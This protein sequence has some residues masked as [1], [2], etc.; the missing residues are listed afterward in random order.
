M[1]DDGADRPR[2]T[3]TRAD[4]RAARRRP[5]RWDSSRRPHALV[6]ARARAAPRSTPTS[7]A[8][9]SATRAL[10][11]PARPRDFR[12][13]VG[14]RRPPGRS[15]RGT[16]P[17]S[18][19]LTGVNDR[20]ACRL[21]P[22]L[23]R[24]HPRRRA[25]RP[26][27]WRA[28]SATRP[29]PS[30]PPAGLCAALHADLVAL[31]PRPGRCRRRRDPATITLTA[32]DAARLRPGGW[33]RW[34]AAFGSPRDA[35]SRP[36]A[37]GLTTLG[38]AGLLVATVPSVLQGR[39]E[40]RRA[41]RPRPRKHRR[42]A[43]AAGRE[44][45][46]QHA[47]PAGPAAA[48]ACGRTHPRTGRGRSTG[49]PASR[50]PGSR[51]GSNDGRAP[52]GSRLGRS[53]SGRHHVRRRRRRA[54]ERPRLPTDDPAT[55]GTERLLVD[56]GTGR[57]PD[58]DPPVGR[59][60]HRRARRCSPSAGRRGASATTEPAGLAS[61]RGP[62]LHLIRA[63]RTPDAARRL[64]ARLPRLLRPAAPDDVQGRARQR[65][66]RLRE[67]RPARHRRTSSP[68]TSRS[69]STC[70]G[71]T[72]RHEQ[73]ADYKATRVTDAGRPARPVPEGPRGGQGAAHPGLRAAGLRGRRRH[74]H[75]H[76]PARRQRRARDDDRDRRSR[77]APAGHAAGPAD[78]DP[79]GRREHGH[80]RRRQDRRAVR[81]APGPDD[82]LQGA[83]GRPDRQH[84]GRARGR[85]ED[86]READPRVRRPRLAATRAS[87][88]SRPSQAARQAAR[89][90]STRSGWAASC[91]RSCATCR[92][93]ST[94][95]RRAS[96]TTT[97]T[98]SSGCSA[99]TSSARSSSG[100]RRWPARRRSSAPSA[101]ASVADERLRAGGAR[102]RPAGWLGT[103]AR[104][105]RGRRRGRAPAP[106][107][108]RRRV[109]PAAGRREL[110]RRATSRRRA[111]VRAGQ[112]PADGPRRG[113]PGSRPD[114]GPRRGPHR[115]P[116]AVAGGPVGGR[117]GARARRSAAAARRRRWRSRSPG[118]D[119]RVVAVDGPEAAAA[120]RHLLERLR[121]PARRARGQADPRRGASPRTTARAPLPVAFDTQ[122]AAYILNAALRSQ[123]IADVV[124]ENARPDPAAAGRAAGHGPGR[125]RGAVGARR[126]RAA[127]A[128]PRRGQPRAPV[129]RGRA[130]ADPGPR[131]DGSGRR[132]PRPRG[133]GR[134]RSRV[135]GRDRA[136]R[137]G[138][139]RTTSAT[140]STSAARSSSS[141]S[142]SSSSTCP[143][144][145]AR[146]P[147][148]RP[149][150]RCSRTCGRR[151]R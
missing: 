71:P 123:T 100:C 57:S 118:A 3:T 29:K 55:P 115:R 121:H 91:R 90:P 105:N 63:H 46:D 117:R 20:Y 77:H 140:S 122:V 60:A 97:A 24:H 135:R 50:G 124:A 51:A 108:L 131:P 147:A 138:D 137:G 85:R 36:L 134:P 21:R 106:P 18:P 43:P 80:V 47:M 83:Q 31:R 148:T 89:A 5:R 103:G 73:Y 56:E 35:F 65:R 2:R 40:P 119:G 67:H 149:T 109:G 4:R 99:S 10:P 25:R 93:S 16:G 37:V 45:R 23:A 41:R 17:S 104:R 151:I 6:A 32:A 92:S 133:A 58:A 61:S 143:R 53:G 127:R 96:A 84:P 70:P 107:R 116:R 132:R 33:R 27:A 26:L 114:R 14:R 94:W 88:R 75:D 112:G 34:V 76:P 62:P 49:A 95:R 146:R 48:P 52:A 22:R 82:R 145:S 128:A 113:D 79:L 44:P 11:V 111:R 69:P 81:P 54:G 9:S 129:P 150:R 39:V 64:R 110:G 42:R 102:R 120:L 1:A 7:L 86:R 87:T 144:A 78:D 125:A 98:R 38:I 15:P 74:R 30:S 72:F 130:A 66:V 8:L 139:L 13:T 68:T 12:L 142:C 59:A 136:A 19:R 126:P 28:P 101:C 141:R